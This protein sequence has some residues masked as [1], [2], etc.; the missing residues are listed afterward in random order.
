M[1]VIKKWF[2]CYFSEPEAVFLTTAILFAFIIF[3]VVGNILV[4][5]IASIVIAY[6]LSGFVEYLV[7]YKCPQLFAVI[8]VYLLFIGVIIVLFIWLLPLLFQQLT[9]FFAEVPRMLGHGQ[10]FLI[11]LQA[12]HTDLFSVAQFKY[13]LGEFSHYVTR[14]GQFV[15][16]FSLAS[17]GNIIT[18]IV[19]LVLVPLLTFFFLKDSRSITIWGK[20]FLPKEH[21]TISKIWHEVNGK[22]GDYVRGKLIEILIVSVVS[23]IAFAVLG[24]DYAVLLCV[25][26]GLSVIIPYIGIILVTI[27][28][29]I[30]AF[31][32]WGW[33]AH[34]FYLLLA[35]TIIAVADANILV[36]I[37]FSEKMKLHPVVIV[38]AVL[39][40]GSLWGFWGVF[41]AIPLATLVNTLLKY[42][43]RKIEGEN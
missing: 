26:V 39:V 5:V 35:Y 16:S 22:I 4:P 23:V 10:K 40:F 34:C 12:Q 8:L 6:I 27:P 30:I 19:Y 1:Q 43:P 9:S 2:Q 25:G 15:V 41:F 21:K 42:W 18:A 14:G 33:S 28:I 11:N 24:I 29:V 7:R 13:V 31:F 38:L 32:Q 17:I 36:P 3:N 20:R 37:L